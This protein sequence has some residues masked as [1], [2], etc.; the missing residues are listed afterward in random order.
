MYFFILLSKL[1]WERPNNRNQNTSTMNENFDKTRQYTF[2]FLFFVLSTF[3]LLAQN[4]QKQNEASISRWSEDK[5]NEWYANQPWPCG[6]NYVPANAISYTEMWMPYCFDTAFISK[7]LMLAEDIGFNCLRVVLPFVVWEYDPDAFKARLSDFLHTCDNHGL[8]VMFTLF[9]DCAFGSDPRTENPSYGKQPEVLKGW[10]ANG[11]TASP[12]HNMVRNPETWPGL[13][14]YVKDILKTFKDDPRVWVWDLYNEPSI[15]DM[16]KAPLALVN[17]VFEWARE[18]NPSQ[19]L[20]I[21]QWNGNQELNHFIHQNNDI[22]T[23]HSYGNPKIVKSIVDQLKSYGRPVINT[24]WLC[25]HRGSEVSTCLPVFKEENVGC[26]L[27]GLVN[28]KT[29]THLHWGWKPGMGEPEVWQHDLFYNDHRPYTSEELNLL[30]A[31][32]KK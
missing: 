10:Y 12:G 31:Y 26:M 19:P 4:N 5:A 27:W 21:G 3:N 29:Q 1:T 2:A 17:R 13:E 22:N 20:T 15:G 25:R 16:G 14:R 28:G 11:W 8:K 6:F 7:E 30:K 18:V 24:E 9:D 23:F 32:N